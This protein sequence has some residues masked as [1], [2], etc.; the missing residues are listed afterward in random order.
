MDEAILPPEDDS[1]DSQISPT[2][3]SVEKKSVEDDRASDA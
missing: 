1:D 2:D 3:N